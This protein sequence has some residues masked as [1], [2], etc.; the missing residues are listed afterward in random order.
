MTVIKN[1][2]RHSSE[3]EDD[4]CKSK[5]ASKNLSKLSYFTRDSF[6]GMACNSDSKKSEKDDSDSDSR[7]EVRDELSFLRQENEELVALLDNHD[8]ILREAKKVRKEL[9]A[10]LHDARERVA[11]LEL[12]NL[13]AKLEIDSLKAA[14]IVYDEVDCGDYSIFLVQACLQVSGTRCS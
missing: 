1:L 3:D 14:P 12:K 5:K 7:D 6:C 13:Y 9:R 11:V 4:R 2:G 10:S 8:H